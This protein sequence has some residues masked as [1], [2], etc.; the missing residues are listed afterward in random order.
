MYEL[1]MSMQD[2]NVNNPMEAAETLEP[3]GP[4]LP[5]NFK[6]HYQVNIAAKGS[7]SRMG[8]PWSSDLLGMIYV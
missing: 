6:G 7:Y 2:D 4:G 3:A 5:E 8:T 1:V